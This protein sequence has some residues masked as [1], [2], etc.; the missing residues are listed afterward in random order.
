MVPYTVVLELFEGD[1]VWPNGASI[2]QWTS[3][4][5]PESLS[6]WESERQIELRLADVKGFPF[7]DSVDSGGGEWLGIL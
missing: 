7:D 2:L 4:F 3:F 1:E 6:S 5:P